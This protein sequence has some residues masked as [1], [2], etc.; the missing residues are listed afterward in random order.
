MEIL[1]PVWTSMAAAA[2]VVAEQRAS[3]SGSQGRSSASVASSPGLRTQSGRPG[4]R[5]LRL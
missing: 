4:E 2:V 1:R 3:I 5:S